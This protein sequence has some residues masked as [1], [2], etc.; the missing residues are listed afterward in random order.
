MLKIF[1]GV[2]IALNTDLGESNSFRKLMERVARKQQV[3]IVQEIG[4]V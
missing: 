1:V 4:Q 2:L 3:V